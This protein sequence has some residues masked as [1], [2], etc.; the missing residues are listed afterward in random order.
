ME[1]KSLIEQE[2]ELLIQAGLEGQELAHR[3]DL[4]FQSSIEDGSLDN[5]IEPLIQSAVDRME[6]VIIP[7]NK[8]IYPPMLISEKTSIRREF[9]YSVFEFDTITLE[10]DEIRK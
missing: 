5:S 3:I 1:N 10:D 2:I 4:L 6:N 7:T 8:F 9:E